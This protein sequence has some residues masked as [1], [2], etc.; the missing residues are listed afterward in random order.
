MRTAGRKR[1]RGGGARYIRGFGGLG[2]HA[3]RLGDDV[4]V[5]VCRT[6]TDVDND[7]F[8]A[9][10]PQGRLVAACVIRAK[11]VVSQCVDRP[12]L[13][14]AVGVAGV[15]GL[16]FQIPCIR[17]PARE[18]AIRLGHHQAGHAAVALVRN[19]V[20][21]LHQ[22]LVF[23]LAVGIHQTDCPAHIAAVDIVVDLAGFG[24]E[25]EADTELV[26]RERGEGRSQ[27]GH[28][29]L[30]CQV[31][32]RRVVDDDQHV[33]RTRRGTGVD[34]D[35]FGLRR[36][37]KRQRGRRQHIF[38]V[39]VL[40][41]DSRLHRFHGHRA[42]FWAL[43]RRMRTPWRTRVRAPVAVSSTDASISQTVFQ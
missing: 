41:A 7:V 8:L 26:F 43:V 40:H 22:G 12:G 16:A 19:L 13:H 27:G 5:V 17:W 32:V 36:H 2:Q 1:D 10:G 33:R 9:A 18:V 31:P 3:L 38:Q 6:V 35:V 21:A 34:V 11:R 20:K 4:V 42:A 23:A 37:R 29:V 25:H 14:S 39:S 30:E 15:V 24:K 28:F